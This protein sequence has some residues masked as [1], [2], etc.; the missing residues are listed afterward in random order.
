MSQYNQRRSDNHGRSHY[1][2]N[3]SSRNGNRQ[4]K[5]DYIHPSKFIQ[6]AKP[7]SVEEYVPDHSFADFTLD[8][9]IQNNLEAMGFVSPSPIQDKTIAEGLLGKDIVGI[10]NTGTGKTAAYMIPVIQRLI[11]EP[12]SKVIVLAPTRELAEQIE[13][14]CRKIAKGS[15]I[16][17][18]LLIG[19]VAMRP[20]LQ[21][22]RYNPRIIIGTP[23][24]I[25]DHLVR[26]SLS[27]SNC[28]I[29]ILD[30]V[31]RMLDMGFVNDIR[32]ILGQTMPQRQ[33]L[34]F[35]ATLDTRVKTII[36]GFSIDPV[37]I[38][39]RTTESSDNVEQN[40]ITYDSA[41]DKMSKLYDVLIQKSSV[42]TL[43]FDDTHRSVERLAKELDAR[44]FSTDSLHGGKSQ[45]Q[46]QR[47][48]KRFKEN[49]VKVLV[50]TD[51][52]AR[53]LDVPDIT[54]V[55]NFSLPQSY[56]DYVHRIGRTGRAGKVGYALTF[57]AK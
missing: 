17:G 42:K 39:V 7:V 41:S 4:P 57:V 16:V 45:S 32:M 40:I 36:E 48:L 8:L 20:Q 46:R 55:I 25:K 2:S 19:G 6:P 24:R 49:E 23:G 27:L 1:P 34:Y 30:E 18:T 38:S 29:V 37:Y 22:L 14:Q 28:N 56:Q 44:G 54:H 26:Q 5:K 3:R 12:N 31:D 50:A 43:V 47:V 13:D 21:E 33:S 10:A 9:L 35:S 11:K 15:G 51:V 53:G 52:A